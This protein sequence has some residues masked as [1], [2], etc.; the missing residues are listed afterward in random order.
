MIMGNFLR[1]RKSIRDFK[2]RSVEFETLEEIKGNLKV[3]ESEEGASNFAFRLYENG[4]RLVKEL[5]GIGGYAGVM[6]DAP[7]YIA[8]DFL[9]DHDSTIIYG[10]YNA[11]KLITIL[12]SKGLATCWIS[13]DNVDDD[14]KKEIF[15]ESTNNIKYIL[16]FGYQQPSPPYSE[17]PFSVKLGI[18]DY[19]FLDEIEKEVD[20]GKLD[21]M[22]LTDLF[23]YLRF[24][25]SNKNLQPW[26]FI[27]KDTS[28]DLLMAYEEWDRHL[29][30]DAGIIMYYFEELAK[31]IGMR[32]KWQLID[33]DISQTERHNYK[34]IAV[35]QL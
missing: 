8:L 29:L 5:S 16:A 28:I 23:Y 4:D 11:Q 22:G 7:H 13:L 15:G 35:Y 33:G 1:N 20:T 26:R 19:V 21:S 30:M 31:S 6:I 17:A 18:E 12:N 34:L 24:A 14:L 27:I 3:L 25:P 2:S 32:S 9:D 10:A